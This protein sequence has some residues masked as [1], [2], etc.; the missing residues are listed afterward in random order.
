MLDLTNTLILYDSGYYRTLV[1]NNHTY[2]YIQLIKACLF[3]DVNQHYQ[4]EVNWY[5]QE[6]IAERIVQRTRNRDTK[7]D[8]EQHGNRH[9]K[10]ERS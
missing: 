2:Q 5:L 10:I 1:F 6:E 4:K 3:L 9:T 7:N 8:P